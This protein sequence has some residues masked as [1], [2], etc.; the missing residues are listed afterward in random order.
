LKKA[1]VTPDRKASGRKMMVVTRLDH[2][3]GER[4]SCAAG[5][6][7]PRIC[8]AGH[9]GAALLSLSK[10]RRLAAMAECAARASPGRLFRPTI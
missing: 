1:P 7:R 4:N 8:K 2:D 3:S 6:T 9:A 10:G 5:S